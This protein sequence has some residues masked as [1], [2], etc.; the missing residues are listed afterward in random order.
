MARF[1]KI[2]TYLWNDPQF[3]ALRDDGKL[4]FLYL[5]TH[6]HLNA[7]GTMRSSL[8]GLASELNWSLERLQTALTEPYLTPNIQWDDAVPFIWITHYI[9]TYPPE[10]PNVVKSWRNLWEQLPQCPLKI[11]LSLHV[12][13]LIQTLTPAFQAAL[14]LCF[15]AEQN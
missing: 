10:S 12:Q 7:L 1:R 2:D 14:P 8:S 4:A 11:Q 9:D 6:P 5:L 13:A 3:N 15:Q